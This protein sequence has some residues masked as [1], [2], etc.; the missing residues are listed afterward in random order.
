MRGF[1]AGFIYR[2][3]DHPSWHPDHAV[4]AVRTATERACSP[5][6]RPTMKSEKSTLSATLLLWIVPTSSSCL[7]PDCPVTQERKYVLFAL[8]PHNL[9]SRCL[10][11]KLIFHSAGNGIVK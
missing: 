6:S 8:L 5:S 9:I 11:R 3:E 7:I 4:P 2:H 1:R 10:R